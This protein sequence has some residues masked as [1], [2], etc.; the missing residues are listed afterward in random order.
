MILD[1]YPGLRDPDELRDLSISDEEWEE[2]RQLCDLRAIGYWANEQHPHLP[3]PHD[4]VDPSWSSSER[5]TV[6]AYLCAGKVV[7]R[8]LGHSWCRFN[9]NAAVL[10]EITVEE[11]EALFEDSEKT[12]QPAEASTATKPR[13]VHDGYTQCYDMGTIC[14][15][16]GTFVWPEGFAHYVKVHAVRPPKDFV[17]H[18]LREVQRR[19]II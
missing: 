6:I 11:F 10:P 9:P 17:R 14:L 1:R 4:F 5:A 12:A 7:R 2:W 16:D 3:N 18:V 15:S 8:W 13:R 19:G